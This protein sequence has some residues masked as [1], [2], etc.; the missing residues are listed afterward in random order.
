MKCLDDLNKEELMDLAAYIEN[1]PHLA[2]KRLFNNAQ[3]RVKYTRQVKNYCWNKYTALYQNG[4][5]RI[6]YISIAAEIWSELPTTFHQL[7]IDLV[8]RRGVK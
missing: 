1:H 6:K 7:N 5:T 2:A 3:S 4:P 8:P